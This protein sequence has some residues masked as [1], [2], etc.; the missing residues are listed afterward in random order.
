MNSY[1]REFAERVCITAKLMDRLGLTAGTSGNI[2][3]RVT[4]QSYAV[5][6]PSGMPYQALTPDDMV[7]VDLS[8]QMVTGFHPASSETPLHTHLYS[9]FESVQAVVHTHSLYATAFSVVRKPIPFVSL[10]GLGVN[11]LTVPV[12]EYALPG[13]PDLAISAAKALRGYPDVLAILLPNHG[14]VTVGA[15]L[16]DA[17]SLAINVER[18]AQILAIASSLGTPVQLS[19]AQL[20]QINATY[21]AARRKT[22]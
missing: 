22:S 21:A 2:S 15:T 5:I 4:G 6:T 16:D 20:S 13:T 3:M 14:L 1:W 10:E 7:V 9:E 12:A 19:A 8:G 11:S 17:F 18:E